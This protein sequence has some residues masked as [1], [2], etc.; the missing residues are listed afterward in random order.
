M[1]TTEV[2]WFRQVLLLLS[3]IAYSACMEGVKASYDN[4]ELFLAFGLV[5]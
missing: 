3:L 4:T 5:R 1:P 2:S